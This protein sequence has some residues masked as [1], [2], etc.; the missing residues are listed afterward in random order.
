MKIGIVIE[1][2]EPEIVWNAFRF[3]VTALKEG[4]N[5]RA[6]LINSGVEAENIEDKQ[7][8]VKEQINSFIVNKGMVMACGTCLNSRSKEGT[9]ICPISTMKDLLKLVEESDNILTFG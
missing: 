1:T 4:H 8:D 6:F 9:K 3:G 7:F 5:V 2:K